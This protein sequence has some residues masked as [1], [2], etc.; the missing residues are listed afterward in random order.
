MAT[1][2]MKRGASVEVEAIVVP[3]WL[4]ALLIVATLGAMNHTAQLYVNASRIDDIREVLMRQQG[5]LDTIAGLVGE[6]TRVGQ[7][8]DS[9]R[10]ILG[11]VRDDVIDLKARQ[12]GDIEL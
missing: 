12:P 2:A 1:V 3:K 5:Q 8:L 4:W 9:I 7:E 11:D 6:A 10:R